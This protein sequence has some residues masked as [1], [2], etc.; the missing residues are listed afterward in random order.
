MV[1][2]SVRL[3]DWEILLPIGPMSLKINKP[4]SHW[5]KYAILFLIGQVSHVR[6]AGLRHRPLQLRQQAGLRIAGVLER[7]HLP[8]PPTGGP[9][10]PEQTFYRLIH[11]DRLTRKWVLLRRSKPHSYR[12]VQ[13][14]CHCYLSICLYDNFCVS[15]YVGWKTDQHRVNLCKEMIWL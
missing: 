11:E 7:P 5:S 3:I 15:M 2:Y 10:S 1:K 12:V 4:V 9:L 13:Q 8:L 14:I 6:P